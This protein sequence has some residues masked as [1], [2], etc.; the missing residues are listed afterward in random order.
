[1]LFWQ[2]FPDALLGCTMVNGVESITTIISCI[3]FVVLV[4]QGMGPGE[5]EETSESLQANQLHDEQM[6]SGNKPA[7]RCPPE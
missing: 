5:T 4:C 6:D 2:E 1:M 7:P 3:N